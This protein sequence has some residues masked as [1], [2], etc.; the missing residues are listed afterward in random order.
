MDSMKPALGV[1][2]IGASVSGGWAMESHLPA[3]R[4]L[5]TF[6]VQAV[7]TSKESSARA[8]AQQLG[9]PRFHTSAQSLASDSAVD[10]VTVAVKVPAHDQAVRA[11]IEA[12]KDVY[13]EWPL[14]TDTTQARALRDLAVAKG[15]R[16]VIGLQARLSPVVCR[17]RDLIAEGFV[18]RVL[19]VQA[20]SAGIALGGPEVP[21]NREWAMDKANGLSALTVRTG[22]TL[23]ALQHCVSPISSLAAEVLVATPDP[24]IAGTDT[25][26][27]KTAPDQVLVVGRLEGGASFSAQMLLGVRPP[28]TALLTVMG[29]EGT[30][31]IIPESAEGQIQMSSLALHGSRHDSDFAALSVPA[32]YV[33]VPADVPAGSPYAV[34]H[35]YAAIGTAADGGRHEPLPTFDDAVRLHTLLDTIEAAAES[36]QRRVVS[37]G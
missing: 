7:A 5:P 1:G 8:T 4:S 15:V 35:L 3:L 12:G 36:G 18:G 28:R 32:E 37:T 24:R 19:S 33:K 34:A 30:L 14:G 20:Q 26:V 13:C 6:A 21:A 17:A 10:L 11:A 25:T 9:V 2:V 22:H 29:T 23:D 27:R 31:A 16:H